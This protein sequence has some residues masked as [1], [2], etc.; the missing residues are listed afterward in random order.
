M[1][2]HARVQANVDAFYAA[3]GPCCAGCDWWRWHN[4][5]A[6]EC[7]KTAP[8]SGIERF[9]MLGATSY[10]LSPGA[11]H[12]MTLRNHLCGEFRDEATDGGGSNG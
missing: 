12:I 3:H 4:S 2:R 10:S 11:G 9:A 7:I 8:T 6:G 1:S 5:L